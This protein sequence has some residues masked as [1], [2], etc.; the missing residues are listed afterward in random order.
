MLESRSLV[1]TLLVV[2]PATAQLPSGVT[3]DPAAAI[4]SYD[5]IDRFAAAF[6]RLPFVRDTAAFLDSAYLARASTGLRVYAGLYDVTGQA[7]RDAIREEPERFGAVASEAP[8]LV[9]ALEEELKAAF[10]RLAALYP[11]AL[12]PTT[13]F[14]VGPRV[15]GGALQR[16]GLFI[17]VE[18]YASPPARLRELTHLVAHEL[19]HY[20]Q[21]AW[22]PELYQ[23]PTTLLGRAIREGSADL[24]AELISGAHINEVAHAFGVRHEALLWS[25]FREE[26]GGTDTGDW[27]FAE[28]A[29]PSWPRDLGYFVGYRIARTR[30]ERE[31]GGPAGIAAVVRVPDPRTFLETTGYTPGMQNEKEP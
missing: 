14:L 1:L 5:D 25:R 2:A 12:F 29:D 9:R 22:N 31:G 4:F 21:A 28:P 3:P 24:I 20:Q 23:R 7:L 27:F 11:D 10:A 30:F 15:A 6:E 19:A 26:M 17:A 16:E 18:T 8:G 13:W